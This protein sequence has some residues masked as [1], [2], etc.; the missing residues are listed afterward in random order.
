MGMIS[1][2]DGLRVG[3]RALAFWGLGQVGVAIKGPRGVLYVDPY[4]TD[5]DG[6]GGSLERTFPPPLRPDEVTNADA[7]L[8][9]HDHIDHTDPK[10]V[11]PL[12]EASPR[13]RIVAPSTSR[14][15]LVEAGLEADRLVVP[16]IGEPV[17][18]AGAT[19]TAV[20]SAHTEL[21]YDPERG[22]AYL[23]YVVECN[24]VTVYHA[25]D[26]VVYEGLIE[27]LSAWKI[28][29]AFVPINGRDFFR[30]AQ[31]I[32]GNTDSREAAQLAEA[33]DFGLI[34]PTHYDL[35]AFNGADP[36]HFVSYLYDLNPMRRH[37]LLRPGELFYFAKDRA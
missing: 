24:G 32:I 37:K 20:P 33:L 29:V 7:V 16:R 19:V 10:T 28:D 17:E 2:I 21:E 14:D 30:T 18:V 4:L 3:E 25:G 8:L 15:T 1:G 12:S 13:A 36:G 23:G 22:H 34:V 11:L 6:G 9:T 35:F 27:R 31:N 26:T 5:S